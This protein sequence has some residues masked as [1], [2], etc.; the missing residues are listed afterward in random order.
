[1]TWMSVDKWICGSLRLRE[2]G[3]AWLKRGGELD[4]GSKQTKIHEP[5]SGVLPAAGPTA[6]VERHT[7][8]PQCEGWEYDYITETVAPPSAHAERCCDAR[9]KAPRFS[10]SHVVPCANRQEK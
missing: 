4:R 7:E 1:M 10:N 5:L 8:F 2:S 3:A 9:D 6:T